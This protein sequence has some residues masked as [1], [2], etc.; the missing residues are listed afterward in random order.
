MAD[1]SFADAVVDVIDDARENDEVEKTLLS[2]NKVLDGAELD[3]SRYGDTLFEVFF[4]GGRLAS[5]GTVSTE[6]KRTQTNVLAAA[7]TRDGIVPY[8]KLFQT[9]IRRRPFLIKALENTLIKLIMSMEF[10]DEE[11]R[12]KIA[13]ALARIFSLK[14]GVLPDH[15]LPAILV[16][17][18][19]L[20]GTV[21]QFVTAFFADF[22]ATDSVEV[23]LPTGGALR[24]EEGWGR[25]GA[26]RGQQRNVDVAGGELPDSASSVN[27]GPYQLQALALVELL[28]KGRVESRLLDFFPPQKRTWE[29]FEEHFKAATGQQQ[30]AAGQQQLVEYTKR[31]LYDQHCQEL[32]VGVK[33]ML[34]PEEPQTPQALVDY[35]K[36]RKADWA[37]QD[38]DIVKFVFLGLVDSVLDTAGAKNTQ[39][40]QLAVLK[41]IRAYEK[42]LGTFCTSARLEAHLLSSMQV[43]CYEDSRLLKLFAEIARVL[44]DTDVVGED[45][46]RY[47]YTKGSNPKGRNVFLKN[48]EPLMKWLDE[49]EEEEEDDSEDE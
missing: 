16:D 37:L 32:R 19:V 48:M 28:R 43:I 38:P 41:Q 1:H 11:G 24:V 30:L 45:T 2:A 13:I 39:Q 20:K 7:A 33:A 34:D 27:L 40:V 22:L 18:L 9:M 46:I 26:R 44:Y 21:L 8:I 14:L 6:G 23:A 47:W 3:F 31:K 17:R 29:E 5:G 12:K 10:F 36:A 4:V 15:V 49:A 25:G 42:V 35:V